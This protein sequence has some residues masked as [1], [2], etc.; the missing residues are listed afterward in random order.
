MVEADNVRGMA[1]ILVTGGAGYIGSHT[2]RRLIDA[3]HEVVVVDDLSAGHR[4]AVA[5][6]ARFVELSLSESERLRET[7]AAAGPDAVLH[8]AGSIEPAESM[9]DPRRHYAN[10]LVNSLT[11][12]DALVDLGAPPI[13]FSSTCAI[14]GNPERVPVAEDDPTVPTSVYGESKLAIE[15]VLAAYDRAYGLRSTSLRY[16]NA[17]GA[18]P[19]GSMGDDHRN[20]IH[21]ITVALLAALGQRTGVSVFGTDYPTPDGTCIRDYI[22]VDDL[23]SAH[24]LAV[25]RLLAGGSTTRFNLGLGEG[26]SVQ[27]VLNTV[28]RVTG[29][30]VARTLATRRAGDPAA[31]YADPSRARAELQWAPRYTHLEDMIETAWRWHRSH[32]DGYAD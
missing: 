27:Q 26:F 3:G 30:E 22:H 6:G 4:A 19:D 21:L 14:F 7:I 9:R 25:E 12:V 18:H 20:K 15:R 2:V 24:V 32:P 1:V 11:L 23:A 13:V 5:E 10:N 17:C 31:L 29:V 28:D 8:F 16:F